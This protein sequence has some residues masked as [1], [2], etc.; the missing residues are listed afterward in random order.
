MSVLV[1]GWRCNQ[2]RT[3]MPKAKRSD[4]STEEMIEAVR[5]YWQSPMVN[6]FPTDA[7]ADKYPPKVVE[8]K[9]QQLVDQGILDYGVSLRTAWVVADKV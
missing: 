9:M 8:A 5:Q 4:I 3:L 7:L 1:S 6:P 2:A